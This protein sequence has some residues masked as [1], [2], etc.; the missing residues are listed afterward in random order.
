MIKLLV[1]HHNILIK[2][3]KKR[4]IRKIEK[5]YHEINLT[6]KDCT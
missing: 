5:Y 2:K 3:N 4:I 6:L 1:S